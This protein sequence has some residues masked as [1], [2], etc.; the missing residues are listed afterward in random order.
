M[1]AHIR[2][3]IRARRL[4]DR[5]SLISKSAPVNLG[6]DGSERLGCASGG[7]FAA[8][9]FDDLK[10]IGVAVVGE[11]DPRI[12][13]FFTGGAECGDHSAASPVRLFCPRGPRLA[14]RKPPRQAIQSCQLNHEKP[15]FAQPVL[16]WAPRFGGG[17]IPHGR[18]H[19]QN[20]LRSNCS[21][22]LADECVG[23]TQCRDTDA[24]TWQAALACLSTLRRKLVFSQRSLSSKALS[25]NLPRR[26]CQETR[27][28]LLAKPLFSSSTISLNCLRCKS[29]I[30]KL[31]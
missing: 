24:C 5:R 13:H 20:Y 22:N 26:V 7:W 3:R 21:G 23:Q 12:L 19:R 18:A 28:L 1:H 27:I 9:P 14:S 6:S 11:D 30:P 15:L 10:C 16:M 29:S 4:Y 8:L 31:R 25:R 2:K 17:A